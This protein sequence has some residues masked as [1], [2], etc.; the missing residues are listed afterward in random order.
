MRQKIINSYKEIEEY[1]RINKNI[2]SKLANI[3][4]II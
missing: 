4:N 3:V 1:E 2:E